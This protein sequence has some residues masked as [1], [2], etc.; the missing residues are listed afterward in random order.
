MVT[1]DVAHHFLKRL[2]GPLLLVLRAPWLTGFTENRIY[3]GEGTDTALL[4][5]LLLLDGDSLITVN[6]YFK[7]TSVLWLRFSFLD[8]DLK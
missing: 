6:I 3:R 4:V 8:L 5:R 2:L 7:K 1:W